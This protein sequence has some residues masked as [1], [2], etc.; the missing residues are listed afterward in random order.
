MPGEEG[1]DD[2]DDGRGGPQVFQKK[3]L[4]H[5]E[6]PLRPLHSGHLGGRGIESPRHRAALFSH[7][8]VQ[9][10]RLGVGAQ[11]RVQC[12]VRA[13]QGLRGRDVQ[14]LSWVSDVA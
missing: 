5:P 8:A 1:P 2:E 4:H 11:A 7:A 14:R 9:G 10:H 12:A 3:V 6:P 13:L